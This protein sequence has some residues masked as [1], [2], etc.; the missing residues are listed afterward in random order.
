VKLDGTDYALG[1]TRITYGLNNRLYAKK[2]SA[3]EILSVGISQNYSTNQAATK[4][5]V[6][7]QS[8]FNSQ[9]P[10]SHLSPV[11]LQVHSSPANGI[12]GTFRAEYN[13]DVHAL[14]TLNA[15][16]TVT[17]GWVQATAGWSQRRFV[18]DLPGFNVE[19]AATQSLQS[20]TSIRKPGN[21]FGGTYTF[22]YDLQRHNYVSQRYVMYY[23][24]QCCGIAAEYQTFN[25]GTNPFA[26]V[27]QDRRFNLSFTLAGIGSFSNLFGAFGSQTR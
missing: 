1:N 11:T 14:Q 2:E 13:T 17:R 16:G 25:F 5:D 7:S 8:G 10:E 6:S 15:N 9:T 3:R 19:A 27:P 20:A 21:A 22:T 12:D 26:A 24:S 4:Y 18:P 23:N